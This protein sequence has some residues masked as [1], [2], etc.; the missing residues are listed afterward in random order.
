M[1]VTGSPFDR[2]QE[3]LRSNINDGAPTR[4]S[5]TDR[6]VDLG[7]GNSLLLIQLIVQLEEAF[8]IDMPEEVLTAA[9]FESVDSLWAVVNGVLAEQG[10]DG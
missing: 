9:A 4:L 3:L 10:T 8:R 6:L 5:P 2:F 7:L 1:M